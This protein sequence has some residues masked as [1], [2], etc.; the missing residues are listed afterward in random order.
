MHLSIIIPAYNEAQRLP[1]TLEAIFSYLQRQPYQ[2]EVLVVDDGSVDGTADLVRAS[3]HPIRLIQQPRNL[4]KGAAIRT[5]MLA[6]TGDWRYTCDADLSTPIDE[7]DHLL[8]LIEQADVIIGSR[9]MP[10]SAVTQAQPRWKVWFGQMGNLAI[11]L[12]AVR[13]LHDTQCGFKL[14]H[15]RTMPIFTMQRTNRF[16]YD[17][18][19]LYLARRGGWKILEVP[20]RWANDPRSTVTTL[21]YFVTFG[22]LV[23]LQWNRWRGYYRFPT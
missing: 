7:L 4:G 11:Q 13:G 23:K 8:S 19:I 17:F 10:G 15:R 2:A 18:E 6:A 1:A 5:G 9:R 21:D 12:L 14:F 20:V 16:G 3:Q 22:E